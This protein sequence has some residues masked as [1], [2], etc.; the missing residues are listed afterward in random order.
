MNN[1]E[2]ETNDLRNK[3]Y[4]L[5]DK[6]MD[7][8]ARTMALQEALSQVHAIA[9]PLQNIGDVM[10]EHKPCNPEFKELAGSNFWDLLTRGR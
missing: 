3:V 6:I 1:N 5:E 10:I 2:Q 4:S 9:L 8:E 7:L